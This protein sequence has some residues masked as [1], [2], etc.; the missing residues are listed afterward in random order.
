MEQANDAAVD[1]AMDNVYARGKDIMKALDVLG[2]K[3][4]GLTMVSMVALG[5]SMISAQGT[6]RWDLFKEMLQNL[7]EAG[8]VTA[9][10]SDK[11]KKEAKI[12]DAILDACLDGVRDPEGV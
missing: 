1:Q 3:A 12:K 7:L 4:D 6:D 2:I 8:D 9:A 11:E 5:M 10:Q